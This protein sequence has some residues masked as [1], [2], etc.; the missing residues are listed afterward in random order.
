[1]AVA[2]QLLLLLGL[3]Q[4]VPAAARV[5]RRR[6]GHRPL[7]VVVLVPVLATMTASASAWVRVP[8]QAAA[9]LLRLQRRLLL[10]RLAGRHDG[11]PAAATPCV[12]CRT[13]TA[14]RRGRVAGR[15]A[16]TPWWQRFRQT[17]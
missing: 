14:Q 2:P 7:Q 11:L 5:R 16:A 15:P 4:L 1:L 6:C 3:R 13:A 8:V 12:G 9:P 17:L 10:L